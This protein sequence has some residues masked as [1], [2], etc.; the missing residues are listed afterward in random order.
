MN[1]IHMSCGYVFSHVKQ[2]ILNIITCFMLLNFLVIGW[3]SLCLRKCDF[4]L[5][6]KSTA[7]AT[8]GYQHDTG[9]GGGVFEK[10]NASYYFFFYLQNQRVPTKRQTF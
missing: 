6:P 3:I 7:T 2:I 9:P 4:M 5:L 10:G 1:S 8:A